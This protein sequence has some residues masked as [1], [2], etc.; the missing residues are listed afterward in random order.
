MDKRVFL[1]AI[2]EIQKINYIEQD[3]TRF[4]GLASYYKKKFLVSREMSIKYFRQEILALEILALVRH[5]R[6]PEALQTMK[7]S[8]E[9]AKKI[10]KR[11]Y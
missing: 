8:L 10:K 9:L 3:W 5:C 4:F 1:P 2:I 11:L 7:W 6:L